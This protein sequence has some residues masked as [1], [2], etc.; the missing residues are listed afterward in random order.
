MGGTRGGASVNRMGRTQEVFILTYF[1]TF[2]K[3]IAFDL[4][5]KE[6]QFLEFSLLKVLICIQL[7]LHKVAGIE[8]DWRLV[9][10]RPL[11]FLWEKL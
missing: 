4:K 7:S 2:L 6:K 1:N 3:N 5:E 8:R 9:H 10:P 11:L